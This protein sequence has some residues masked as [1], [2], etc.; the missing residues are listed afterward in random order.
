MWRPFCFLAG[1]RDATKN[2]N[3]IPPMPCVLLLDGGA[4]VRGSLHPTRP[5][6]APLSTTRDD[7]EESL[8]SSRL[9][10]AG[11]WLRGHPFLK[12]RAVRGRSTPATLVRAEAYG[13]GSRHTSAKAVDSSL[14][15]TSDD[16]C[17]HLRQDPA[18]Q[19]SLHIQRHELE[20]FIRGHTMPTP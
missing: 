15:R 17:A 4:A 7:R 5:H 3:N 13:T 18:S 1:G 12:P 8:A 10:R 9:G 2:N 11:N 16:E 20:I 6:D 19:L 14:M